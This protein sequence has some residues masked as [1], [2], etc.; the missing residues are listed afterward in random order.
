MYQ[1]VFL[2]TCGYMWLAEGCL[3][4]IFFQ[5][6]FL[7]EQLMCFLNKLFVKQRKSF[8]LLLDSSPL[9]SCVHFTTCSTNK[10]VLF[11]FYQTGLPLFVSFQSNFA[12]SRIYLS[13]LYKSTDLKFLQRRSKTESPGLSRQYFLF[14]VQPPWAST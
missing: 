11:L 13:F 4:V 10:S 6:G 2:Y 7:K 1:L 8:C 3:C 12:Q 9:F 14:S 5:S